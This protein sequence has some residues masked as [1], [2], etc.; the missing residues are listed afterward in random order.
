MKKI[1]T[2]F[3]TTLALSV[4]ASGPLQAALSFTQLDLNGNYRMS[5][6]GSIAGFPLGSSTYLGGVPFTQ[7]DLQGQVWNGAYLPNGTTQSGSAVQTLTINTNVADA[8]GFYSVINTWWGQP[9]PASYASI[10]FNFSDSSSFTKNFIGNVDIR[11]F[12]YQTLTW[13]NQINNTSTRNVY[14]NAADSYALDRQWI[15]FGV[16]SG[17]TLTGVT[18]TDSG[19]WGFQRYLV[20]GATVQSGFSGQIVAPALLPGQTGGPGVPDSAAV[21]EPGQVAAPLL[22]LAGIGGYVFIKRRKTAK[23]ALAPIAA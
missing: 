17:K 5:S 13:T 23:P 21:P 4:A 2:L 12:N 11:D 1:T 22:L 9:G 8:R 19:N 10:T 15:D 14:L 3:A 16:Y 6:S 18:F 20:S 7:N